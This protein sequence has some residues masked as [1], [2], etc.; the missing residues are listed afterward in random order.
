MW[1][2]GHIRSWPDQNWQNNR[3]Q[4]CHGPNG[5]MPDENTTN[6]NV[7]NETMAAR[8]M[9]NEWPH[10]PHTHCSG[11]VVLCQDLNPCKP[12]VN[13]H[14]P[15]T[16][17]PKTRQPT[18]CQTKTH[19]T[20]RAQTATHQTAMHPASGHMNHTPTAADPEPPEMTQSQRVAPGT[21]H[22]LWQVCGTMQVDVWFY[23]STT[24]KVKIHQMRT[25]EM[26][27][28]QMNPPE[29][30]TPPTKAPTGMTKDH[31]PNQDNATPTCM[32]LTH[33]HSSEPT[34]NHQ[35]KA[36]PMNTMTPPN[37]HHNSAKQTP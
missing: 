15:M 35:A 33:L 23:V 1:V 17:K 7:M 5:N 14:Q 18:T 8:D 2:C 16:H 26:D 19:Q 13:T 34:M 27:T 37:E 32:S 30:T 20:M 11:C 6:E 29:T 12:Q 22:P 24:H 28:C 25:N 36:H 21:T 3:A 9:P 10:E 31:P 4:I